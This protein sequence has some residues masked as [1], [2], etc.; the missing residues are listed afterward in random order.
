M[1]MAAPCTV[2]TRSA[3]L[4]PIRT[5]ESNNTSVIFKMMPKF[6]KC[7]CPT[8]HNTA[9]RHHWYKLLVSMK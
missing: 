6:E 3:T 9:T 7:S 8:Q 2:Y 5:I 1:V 4:C